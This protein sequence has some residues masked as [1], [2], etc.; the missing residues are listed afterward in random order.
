MPTSFIDAC[1][2]KRR[3]PTSLRP[4]CSMTLQKPELF[5]SDIQLF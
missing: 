3:A 2:T 5:G 1:R 4:E